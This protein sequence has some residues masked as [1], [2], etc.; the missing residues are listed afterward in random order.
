MNKDFTKEKVFLSI[1][2]PIYNEEKRLFNLHKIFDFLKKSKFTF[3]LIII[4]DG[5]TDNTLSELKKLQKKHR[6]SIISYNNN[7]GKGYAIKN[8]VLKAAGKY[9]L[10]ID[11]DLSTPIEEFKKFEP[12]LQQY[13]VIIASRRLPQSNLILKQSTIREFLGKTFTFLSQ[14]ILGVNISDFTCGFKVF[15]EKASREIFPK[16][17]IERWGFDSEVLF[18]AQKKGL[19]I[20]EVSVVWKNNPLTKVKFP[21]DILNSLKELFSIRLNDFLGR[22]L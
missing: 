14:I 1:I 2:I 17:T 18:I 9:R 4:N 22:Y 20:K 13:D 16:L 7:R 11:I 19:S 12:F 8:G 3:E 21:R 5:S 10:F 6:F 15:S